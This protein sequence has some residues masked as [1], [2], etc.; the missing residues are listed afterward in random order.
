VNDRPDPKKAEQT[1][2]SDLQAGR[3]IYIGSI[4]QIVNQSDPPKPAESP[5]ISLSIDALVE[6]VRSL[7]CDKIQEQCGIMRLLDIS[8]RVGLD[9]LYVDVNILDDIPN[10]RWA[11]ITDRLQDFDPTADEFERFYLGQVRQA[12]VPGLEVAARNPKLMVL[13]KPGSGKTTFLKH[14]AIECNKGTFHKNYVPLFVV[15]KKFTDSA[16]NTGNLNLLNYI[17]RELQV[18]DIS[19]SDLETLLKKGR[20]LILLDGLDEVSEQDSEAVRQEIM[21]LSERY[22]RN[23]FLVTCRTQAQKYI[24]E[25]F[26][27]VEVADFNSKQIET[28]ANKWFVA[29][30]RNPEHNGLVRATEFIEKLNSPENRRVRELAVTP[31]LLSLTC[32]VFNDLE[33]LPTNRANLYERGLNILL[34]RWD[35]VK[36]IQR[37]EIYHDL[38]LPRKI[39]LLSQVAA[40]T[41]GQSDYFFEQDKIQRYIADYLRTLPNIEANPET[42]QVGSQVVLESIE[43]QHGLL[44]ERSRGIYSFSHLTFQEYFTAR[45]F[46]ANLSPELLQFLVSKVAES[47]W[48]EVFLL[49]SEMLENADDLLWLMKQQIHE[50][51]A[52]DK[53]LQHFLKWVNQKALSVNVPCQPI[54]I[55]AFCFALGFNVDLHL[56]IDPSHL[57]YFDAISHNA[58]NAELDLAYALDLALKYSYMPDPKSIQAVDIATAYKLIFNSAP[59]LAE[60][61]QY[62]KEQLPE[63][64]GD[65]EVLRQ[66]WQANGKAWTEQLRYVM[67]KHCRIGHNWQF[68]EHQKEFLKKYYNA[69]KLLVDCL[70]SC[71]VSSQVRLEIEATLLLPKAEIEK[72]Q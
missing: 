2:A 58:L 38:S 30:A 49:T 3:D 69:N 39:K 43:V 71:K 54:A 62:L 27:Y 12:R 13:G 65:E 66:W 60:S 51:I 16:K 63:Q 36:G 35:E 46:V 14:I 28:F 23:R 1:A 8:H 50:L 5:Q 6:Q 47:R 64:K 45:N 44:V 26:T 72:Q 31:I 19:A 9:E 55:R 15:L 4:T 25:Y 34:S 10:Q 22:Y 11:R 70:S 29:V 61:L 21:K 37:N 59:K 41:F 17:E 56:D 24:F 68:S 20:F 18:C 40:I 7:V 32:L 57:F 67:I 52:S 42:L 48:R 53:N 33:D